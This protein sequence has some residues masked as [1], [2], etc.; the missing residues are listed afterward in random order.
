MKANRLQIILSIAILSNLC[1]LI[2][3]T[4]R[5]STTASAQSNCTPGNT[6]PTL[7]QNTSWGP[8]QFI[9]V[10]IDPR[11]NDQQRAAIRAAFDNWNSSAQ[12]NNSRVYFVGFTYN[13]SPAS[14]PGL[15]KSLN[16]HQA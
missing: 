1:L 16:R 15:S 4:N 11:Y 6:P 2:F 12:A 10:N 8:G 3:I 9:T 5:L 14:G 7:P 13:A